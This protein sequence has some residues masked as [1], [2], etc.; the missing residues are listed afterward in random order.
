MTETEQRFILRWSY[1]DLARF[2]GYPVG[3]LLILVAISGIPSVF[4]DTG[5]YLGLWGVIAG[6][7]VSILLWTWFVD[8][9]VRVE[10]TEQKVT[11]VNLF[12]RYELPWS[13]LTYVDLRAVGWHSGGEPL[14]YCLEFG[15]PSKPIAAYMPRGSLLRMTEIL[16]RVLRSR[17]QSLVNEPRPNAA[18]VETGLGPVLHRL[19]APAARFE[20]S[21]AKRL[22]LSKRQWLRKALI[23]AAVVGFYVAV[24]ILD[25]L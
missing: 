4:E 25:N 16:N 15:T 22:G 1:R 19:D 17:D 7:G 2:I 23:G 8:R 14:I 11:V 21:V 5:D 20:A 3:G 10:V 24:F 13:A 12:T 9:R 18:I 6:L